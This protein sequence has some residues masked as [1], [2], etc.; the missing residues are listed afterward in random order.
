MDNDL[1]IN[2][3]SRVSDFQNDVHIGEPGNKH[4]VIRVEGGG[5]ADIVY[6]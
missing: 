2:T 1:M 6:L 4:W 5:Y 3:L